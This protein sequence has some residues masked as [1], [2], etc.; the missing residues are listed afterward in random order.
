M[1]ILVTG[2]SGFLGTNLINYL[3]KDKKNKVFSIDSKTINPNTINKIRDIES[4]KLDLNNK[5][6]INILKEIE[7]ELIFNLAA[8]SQV[9]KSS[10]NP[11]G[12]YR[13][14]IFGTVNLLESLRLLDL[15]PKVIH[16]STDKVYGISNKLPYKENYKLSSNFTYDVSKI[17]ADLIAQNYKEIY[18]LDINI[19]RS[20][21]IYGPADL[22]FDRLIPHIIKFLLNKKKP[23]I[24]SN[25][26]FLREYIYVNDLI[27]YLMIL[28]KNKSDEYIFNIGSG[29]VYSVEEVFKNLSSLL[30]SKTKPLILDQKLFE[31]PSQSIDMKKFKS[32]FNP[33]F[34]ITN[35]KNGLAKTISWYKEYFGKI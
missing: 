19:F 21:N 13:S 5:K 35:L 22:N 34:Q 7:P 31:I 33:N 18:G 9:L 27:R 23:I 16:A 15:N 29:Q 26:K 14:N 4:F 11:F 17:S 25:G 12:T 6:L 8:E 32:T 28:S 20:S 10:D 1:R 30:G 3:L 24:R 2:G